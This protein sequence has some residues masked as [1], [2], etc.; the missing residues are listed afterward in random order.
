MTTYDEGLEIDEAG[1]RAD[2]LAERRS[3][4][5]KTRVSWASAQPFLAP[6]RAAGFDPAGSARRRRALWAE[7]LVRRAA[8]G[9]GAVAFLVW[10]AAIASFHT[11]PL[12]VVAGG[13]LAAAL[14][15]SVL[16]L[17]RAYDS[18]RIGQGPEEFGAVARAAVVVSLALAAFAYSLQLLVPRRYVLVAV[19]LAALATA[20]HRYLLRGWLN[21]QRIAGTSLLRTLVVGSPSAVDDV[22]TDLAAVP[23]HGYDVVGACVPLVMADVGIAQGVTV[24]GSLSEIPQAVVDHEVDVVIVAGAGL[25]SSSLRRLSWALERTGTDLVVAPGLVEVAGPRLHVRPAAG[26][27]LLHVELPEHHR[28]RLLGKV[29]LDRTLGA[30]LFVA[31]LPV[32]AAASLAVVLTSRGSPFYRQERIGRDGLP[33]TLVKLR[34]MVTDADRLRTDAL[35]GQSDRDG[36]MFKMRRDPRVTRVGAVLRRYS[37]DEL[38][39]LWNVV[40]GEMSLV[41]PRPPLRSEYDQYHDAVQRRMRV[42]PGL[43][44]LW[45]VSGRAD[46][47]WEE[48]VRLD[49][50][51]VDNWSV[52]FDLQILWKTVRAVLLGSGAY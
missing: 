6:G 31:A 25:S 49:L 41:G 4:T 10:G 24:V 46:L 1:R 29:I 45:Q 44:G 5:T 35:L 15:C 38:P 18:R 48:S 17:L 40:K 30:A 39:Q 9:D 20:A 12:L 2:V 22:I 28:G 37:L 50:R 32:L 27:S 51:Y 43:T 26:L 21:R 16:W 8:A 23:L 34:S 11:G 42:K 19:P 36:L 13:L 47:S 52:A 3:A 33:F 14:W 7:P